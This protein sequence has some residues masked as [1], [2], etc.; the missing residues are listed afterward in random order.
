M[1]KQIP[2]KQTASRLITGL[3]VTRLCVQ[4]AQA[5]GHSRSGGDSVGSMYCVQYWLKDVVGWYALEFSVGYLGLGALTGVN[6]EVYFW[7][8]L[9]MRPYVETFDV[10]DDDAKA[11]LRHYGYETAWDVMRTW[12]GETQTVLA[13]LSD[14]EVLRSV[15]TRSEAERLQDIVGP[16]RWDKSLIIRGREHES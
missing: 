15:L 8:P 9:E 14:L 7:L 2:Q 12:P 6:R 5:V 1:Y 16:G 4:R 11:W 10:G 3:L 13:K